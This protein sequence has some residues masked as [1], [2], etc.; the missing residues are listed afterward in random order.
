MELI[1]LNN[2]SVHYSDITALRNVSLSVDSSDFIGVIGP[3]GGGKTSLVK[4]IM[5]L[6][7]YH[8]EIKYFDGLGS[9]DGR[10]GH[11]GY[12]PQ[13]SDI[14]KSFPISVKEVVMSGLQSKKGIFSRYNKEDKLKTEAILGLLDISGIARK[15]IGEISGGQMQRALLGRAII[16]EPKVLILD[17]PTN[18]VDNKFEKQLYELLKELNKRMAIIMVSHDLG[19]I[20]SYVRSILCVNVEVHRHNSNIITAEQLHNYKCPLQ[21]ISHGEVPHIVLDRHR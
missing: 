21:V 14:D 7:P 3:N 13:V 19:T 10:S 9:E 16:S 18:F 15:P 20:S 17:E 6:T 2:V 1:R 12:L 4:A 5:G 8:G 11:I